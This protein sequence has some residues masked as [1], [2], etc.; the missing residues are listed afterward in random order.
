MTCPLSPCEGDEGVGDSPAPQS[1]THRA[2]WVGPWCRVLGEPWARDDVSDF[3]GRRQ[4]EERLGKEETRGGAE[5]VELFRVTLGEMGCGDTR[6][7]PRGLV[8]AVDRRPAGALKARGQQGVEG[9][10]SV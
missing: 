9:E 2:E 8:W 6:G 1:R 4:G 5:E 3:S 10:V 7:S